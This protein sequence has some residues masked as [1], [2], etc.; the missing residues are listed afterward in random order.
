MI[1][2]DIGNTTFHF[3]IGKKHKKYSLKEDIPKFDE[4]IFF[5][6]VNKKATKKLLKTNPSA[7]NIENYIDFQTI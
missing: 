5:I 2:C 7:I 4:K 1:L 6:S 3:L